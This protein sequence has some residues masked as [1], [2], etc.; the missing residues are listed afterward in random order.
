MSTHDLS[1]KF[2]VTAVVVAVALVAAAA[3]P[4]LDLAARIVG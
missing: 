3:A 1:A 2:R 4:V